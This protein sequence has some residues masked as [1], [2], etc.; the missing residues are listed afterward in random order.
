M[1]TTAS[2]SRPATARCWWS[3]R[4]RRRTSPTCATLST[5]DLKPY[6]P[7]GDCLVGLAPDWTGTIWW[8]SRKGLV[9]TIAADTGQVRVTDLGEDVGRQ[10]ATDESG[11]YVVTDAALHRLVAG[12]DGTPQAVW[13]S[14]YDGSSG[15]APVLLDGGVVAITDRADSRLGVLFVARD[16][17]RHLCRQSVFEEGNGATV[18]P[19]APLGRGVVVTN[20]DGYSSPR[21]TLLGFT[22][23]PGVARV[24]LVDDGCVV[25]WTSD[26][27]SPSSGVTVS[28]PSG[29]AYA[30]TKRPSLTGVSAW[31]L[32][33][34]RPAVRTEHVGGA[35]RHRPARR[36]PPLRGR[37][38]SRR[39]GVARHPLR[40]RA[41]AGPLV[42][43]TGLR[44]PVTDVAV[45][46]VRA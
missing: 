17:G 13:R 14:E 18:S 34:D 28:R 6:V 46:L 23:S 37:P 4:G 30:W 41:G 43:P 15:S 11:A 27:V 33:R 42:A 39:H 21:S 22:S 25:R 44:P 24:D 31:H 29:L 36:Q 20:N 35:D 9:G 1:R 26:A 7:F 5:T 3:A 8:A 10:L 19:L 2:W 32:D 40:A 12:A 38:R 16:D 45:V